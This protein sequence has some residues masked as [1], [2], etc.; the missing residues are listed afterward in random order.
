MFNFYCVVRH[1]GFDDAF[2]FEKAAVC[3][4]LILKNAHC[5]ILANE[6]PIPDLRMRIYHFLIKA[7]T[8]AKVNKLVPR[9][10]TCIFF[11]ELYVFCFPLQVRQHDENTGR[12]F[13]T[14]IH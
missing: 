1:C 8:Q 3:S 6:N 10:F 13:D 12:F 5:F 4:K 14:T 9:S 11:D 7:K 2:F